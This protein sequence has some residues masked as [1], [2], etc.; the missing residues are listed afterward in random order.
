MKWKN[1]NYVFH[2]EI[3]SGRLV[4]KSKQNVGDFNPYGS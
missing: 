2:S 4:Y 1:I 3:I